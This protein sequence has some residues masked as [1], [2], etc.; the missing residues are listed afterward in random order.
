LNEGQIEYDGKTNVALQKYLSINSGSE[1]K[2]EIIQGEQGFRLTGVRIVDSSRN[3]N[4]VFNSTKEIRIEIHYSLQRSLRGFRI[5]LHFYNQSG[6]LAFSGSDQS[7]RGASKVGR[8]DYLSVCTIPSNIFNKGHYTVFLNIGIPGQL[9]IIEETDVST[10]YVES[11]GQHGALHN[12]D[13]PGVLAPKLKW[14]SDIKIADEK[15]K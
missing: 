4:D 11:F 15:Y 8:G 3:E 9:K 13:W 6:I 2:F 1:D 5:N 14:E 12:E 10:F 7:T